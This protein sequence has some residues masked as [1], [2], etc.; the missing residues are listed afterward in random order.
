MKLLGIATMSLGIICSNANSAE[1]QSMTTNTADKQI[2]AS[3]VDE[4]K[5]EGDAFLEKNKKNRD[6]ITL[7]NGLQYKILVQ[8][9]GP[10]PVET[11]VVSVN[12]AGTFI[13]GK[14]FDS[15][16]TRHEPASFPV[17]AVIPGWTEALKLMPVGST[18]MLYIPS[19]LAY[20]E[21][22]SPPTIPA[23]KTLIF[24]VELLGI[25]K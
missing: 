23:N 22:G 21:Q 16:Y 15:S 9:K 10:K 2:I 3:A 25:K 8:G 19:D 12:Y 6:I 1:I 24:K 17:G 11:D 5:A 13:N 7:S 18:W 4:N 14:E 20:G